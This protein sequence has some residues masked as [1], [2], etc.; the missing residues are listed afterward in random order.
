MQGKTGVNGQWRG[1]LFR[2]TLSGIVRRARTAL[3]AALLA[4]A[5][6]CGGSSPASP[7][8]SS[9]S[10]QAG[11]AYLR[12]ILALMQ[13]N[14]VNRLRIDWPAFQS[15]VLAK[16]P[17]AATIADTYPAIELALQL[18][19]DHHSIY[20]KANNAGFI[21]SPSSPTGCSI[22]TVDDPAVPADIGYVRV[23]SFSGANPQAFA[24][25]IQDAIR[26]RDAATLAGWIVDLRG[27]T[28]GNMW[29]ML[30]GIGPVLGTG[31]AGYFVL[32]GGAAEPWAYA[33]G[34]AY[35]NGN[36]VVSAPGFYDL[37]RRDPRVAVLTDKR[38]VSSGEAIAVAFR[39]RP[40]TRTLGTETCGVT[41]A[42]SSYTL[43]DG[44]VL[45]LTTAL[46]ADRKQNAYNA[47]L[48]PDEV[49]TDP[50]ALVQRAI[51]WIR[52]GS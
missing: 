30:A 48:P 25:S 14:S 38:V 23:A 6:A 51:A 21:T 4:Q 11:D 22:A 16:A 44:G 28:G 34:G 10:S 29:P 43:T 9:S 37:L 8:G 20:A 49:I 7:T 35:L 46:F 33:A 36:V 24:V 50:S 5:V 1:G 12:A 15:Q 52:S 19:D 41:I 39:G 45:S 26:A 32:A 42:N 18:L 40:N 2:A 3:V 47:P 17:N 27:N 31:T 13:N